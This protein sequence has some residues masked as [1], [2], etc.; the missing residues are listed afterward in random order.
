MKTEELRSRLISMLHG[1]GALAVIGIA[2]AVWAAS[3]GPVERSSS[4][5]LTF[6]G[7]TLAEFHCSP[8]TGRHPAV[9]LLHGAGYRGL[10]HDDFETMC[11]AL[12]A[13]G[14]FAEFIEYFDAGSNTDP[15]TDGIDNFQTWTAA[16]HAGIET[17]AKN[18]AVD[19]K[20]IA[21]MGFSQGAY[22]AVGCGALFSGDIAA[23]VEYYGGLIPTLRDQ[24]ASMPPT[25]I[26]HGDADTI[27]PVSEAKDFDALLAKAGR[28]HE[29]QLY[30]GVEHG[31]NFHGIGDWYNRD[32]ADDAWRRTL[33]F[34]D[35]TLRSLS[36]SPSTL[37]EG[38]R[39]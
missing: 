24:A 11:T 8:G 19:S 26:I 4:G 38:A 27:I 1:S 23:I 3:R 30:P 2:I 32:A 6:N 9:I 29:M 31:F 15:A 39:G 14:Y 36:G 12:A 21:V 10:G 33:E 28:P 17:L 22:L 7:G 34:L 13:H 18:P 25:L 20:R 37:G 35:R 16:I 5:E